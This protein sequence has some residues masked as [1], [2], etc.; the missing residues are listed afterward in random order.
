MKSILVAA[1]FAS[2]ATIPLAAQSA[3]ATKA[4]RPHAT[5]ALPD[6]IQWGPGPAVLP[7]GARAA[8]LEGNPADAGPFTLRLE[9][10]SGYRIPPHFHHVPEHVT[11]M[12]GSFYVGM[13][14]T[15]DATKTTE[16]TAGAFGV[17][18][19]GMRHFAT[20]K[21]KTVIQ[22]HGVGPWSLVYVNPADDPRT[23]AK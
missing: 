3:P 1:A 7:A 22:L 15:F 12:S 8:I 19:P 20:T 18:E 21:V 13:G 14:E 4:E 9:L 11:V 16:L 23:K 10:P 5:I 2:L 6:N 17:I